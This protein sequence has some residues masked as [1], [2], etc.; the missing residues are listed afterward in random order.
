MGIASIFSDGRHKINRFLRK[1]RQSFQLFRT[2]V[3]L[4]L[5]SLRKTKRSHRHKMLCRW[6]FSIYCTRY[7][8]FFT[9]AQTLLR[10]FERIFQNNRPLFCYRI[11]I[12]VNRRQSR[13][14][15]A[16]E[17]AGFRAYFTPPAARQ[18]SF[19]PFSSPAAPAFLRRMQRGKPVGT[20]SPQTAQ[21][22]PLPPCGPAHPLHI[23]WQPGTS[24]RERSS[25][26]AMIFRA[27][28]LAAYSTSLSEIFLGFR[29]AAIMR[30]TSRLASCANLRRRQFLRPPAPRASGSQLVQQIRVS[31]RPP[32]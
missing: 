27:L 21:P 18:T 9:Q 19:S 15:A 1:K 16:A 4:P 13:I 26:S 25:A 6:H 30:S 11:R 24:W 20:A 14:S 8:R 3:P 23:R 12:M 5:V 22:E 2:C 31:S 10:H 28:L 7:R 32:C 17:A 29:S